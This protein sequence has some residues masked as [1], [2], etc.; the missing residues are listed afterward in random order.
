MLLLLHSGFVLSVL[1]TIHVLDLESV[2]LIP[3]ILQRITLDMFCILFIVI[4]DSWSV[5]KISISV[6]MKLIQFVVVDSRMYANIGMIHRSGMNYTK[7]SLKLY[8]VRSIERIHFQS[9]EQYLFAIVGAVGVSMLTGA[10]AAG[11]N[12]QTIV[13][14]DQHQQSIGLNSAVSQNCWLGIAGS[15]MDIVSGG[16]MAAAAKTAQ[17]AATVPLAGQIAIKSVA[18]SSCVLNSLA[19]SNGLANIIVKALN[20]KEITALDVFQWT[21]AVLFFTHCYFDTSGNV[22]D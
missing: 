4:V 12:I 15:V 5:N 22:S 11:R 13:D 19:V 10:Y 18:V 2:G 21:S 20:E 14:R 8:R 1:N 9:R 7:T 17:A 6:S 16:T 3:N